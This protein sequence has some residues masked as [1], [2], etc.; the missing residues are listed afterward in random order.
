MIFLRNLFFIV[1][2]IVFN[3]NASEI[4]VLEIYFAENVENR[5][6]INISETF[7]NTIKRVYCWTKIKAENPP[8]KIYHVWYHKDK[9]MARVELDIKY[10]YFRTWSYKTILSHWIGK[11]KVVVEDKNGNPLAEKEFEIVER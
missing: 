9:E 6:P 10:P 3:S 8:T 7:P 4:K 11:W 5:K 1:L 2:M